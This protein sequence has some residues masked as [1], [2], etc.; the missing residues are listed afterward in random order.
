MGAAAS[1]ALIAIALALL[2]QSP[3][4]LN[5]LNL[6]GQ[7]FDLRAKSFTGYGFAL[8]LLAMVAL[9]HCLRPVTDA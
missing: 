4:L 8:L 5:R 3:R 2:A 6:T 1:G 9:N 7:R